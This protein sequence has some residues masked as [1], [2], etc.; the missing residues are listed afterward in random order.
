[1]LQIRKQGHFLQIIEIRNKELWFCKLSMGHER[2]PD[3]KQRL[4]D[5]LGGP[6]LRQQAVHV[7]RNELPG[8]V[9][10]AGH[11]RQAAPEKYLEELAEREDGTR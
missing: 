8:T 4:K 1:M 11:L 7:Q 3:K 5:L 9:A 10:P 2:Y 6:Y